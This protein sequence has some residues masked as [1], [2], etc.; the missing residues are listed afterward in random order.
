MSTD[1]IR[2]GEALSSSCLQRGRT[3]GIGVLL[4][5]S[6]CGKDSL[7]SPHGVAE[8]TAPQTSWPTK[9]VRGTENP[10]RSQRRCWRSDTCMRSTPRWE[11]GQPERIPRRMRRS[12]RDEREKYSYHQHIS[13]D[14]VPAVI[15]TADYIRPSCGE[16]QLGSSLQGETMGK[17]AFCWD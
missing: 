17:A 2:S 7:P 9:S 11:G 15:L 3:G 13:T 10:H 14:D 4:L 5:I 1:L 12:R 6:R 16:G 8:R